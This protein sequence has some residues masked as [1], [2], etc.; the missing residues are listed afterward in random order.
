MTTMTVEK[1]HT[2]TIDPTYVDSVISFNVRIL[3]AARKESQVALGEALG[4]KRAAVSQKMTGKSAWSASDLVIT[5]QFL[6]VDVKVLLDNSLMKRMA[7]LRNENTAVADVRPRYFVLP[8]PP[9]GLE[10][11]T[12]DLKGRCS[13]H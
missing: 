3:L 4:I 2:S 12:H 7:S 11:T 9:V 5:A 1:A 8:V 13:N 10:P 6:G